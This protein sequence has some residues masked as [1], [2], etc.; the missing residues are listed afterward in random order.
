MKWI[1]TEV[2]T[3]RCYPSLDF[4]HV[5]VW[6]RI[7]GTYMATYSRIDDTGFYEWKDWNGIIVLPPVYWME[8]PESP[9][10]QLKNNK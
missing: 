2:Q 1:K 5:I 4:V 7:Y 9:L 6:C 3:P 8:M 10:E